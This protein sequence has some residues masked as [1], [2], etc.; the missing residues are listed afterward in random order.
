MFHDRLRYGFSG[1]VEAQPALGCRV[2]WALRAA[3]GRQTSMHVSGG[4]PAAQAPIPPTT[5]AG[6]QLGVL[7]RLVTLNGVLWLLLLPAAAALMGDGISTASSDE[8]VGLF[9][10]L[11]VFLGSTALVN[12][13][14]SLVMGRALAQVEGPKVARLFAAGGLLQFTAAVSGT[15]V[16][17]RWDA[18]AEESMWW[19]VGGLGVVWLAYAY[20]H[21]Q[22]ARAARRIA[23]RAWRVHAWA[24]FVGLFWLPVLGFE[25]DLDDYGPAGIGLG[26]VQAACGLAFPIV[27]GIA[28]LRYAAGLRRLVRNGP[29]AFR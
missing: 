21:L 17:G 26:I 18:W 7:P 15:F 1:L 11:V 9:I 5:P 29:A 12:A 10:G 8:Q 4:S 24:A 14:F 22:Q 16:F 2:D 25:L 28:W 6:G 13:L 3:P 19:T 20:G 23:P 27:V